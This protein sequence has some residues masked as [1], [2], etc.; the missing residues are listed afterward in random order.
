[1]E[2]LAALA[3]RADVARLIADADARAVSTQW[4]THWLLNHEPL[5]FERHQHSRGHKLAA[6]P[7]IT[8]DALLYSFDGNGEPARIR[9]WSGFL[10]RWHE[11]EV[12]LREGDVI[13]G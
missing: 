13:T 5:W 4:A 6:Q 11:D 3:E 12:F 2:S 10:K 8:S 1:M 7:E 9:R